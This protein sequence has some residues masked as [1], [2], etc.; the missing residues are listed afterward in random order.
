MGLKMN[1]ELIQSISKMAASGN[2][3]DLPKDEHFANYAQVKKCLIDGGGKYNKCGFIFSDDAGAV[4]SRL[5]GGEAINDKKKYQFFPTPYELA[6]RMLE[7][8]DIQGC[9]SILEPSAGQGAITQL[10]EDTKEF[11]SLTAVELNP[12]NVEKLINNSGCI[13]IIEGDFLTQ[14]LESF[15]RIVANP[16][17]TKN[18][19]IDHIKHMFSLLNPGGKLV[20]IASPSWTFGR[21]KK[22]VAFRKWLES[23]N[24][25]V[26]DVPAGT[27]KESGTQIRAVIVEIE[28]H[29]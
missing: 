19:D 6:Y 11:E 21:Q 15:D 27:F 3:L 16:P 8:A 20:S 10:I 14:E 23:V 13:T 2:R 22:Q 18:Q 29:A 1:A 7:M 24:A 25:I 12:D 4:K 17:F 26:T 28:K 5:I 9:H